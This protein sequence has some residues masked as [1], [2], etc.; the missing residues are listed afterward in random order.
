MPTTTANFAD[1][2]LTPSR[3]LFYALAVGYASALFLLL[4]TVFVHALPPSLLV[5]GVWG[6][7]HEVEQWAW[8]HVRQQGRLVIRCDGQ[9]Q[10]QNTSW[11]LKRLTLRTP[12]LVVFQLRH[13]PSPSYSPLS[14]SCPAKPRTV[15]VA[16]TPDSCTASAY[17]QV[18]LFARYPNGIA[19]YRPGE[20]W[21]R[22]W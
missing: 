14:S 21:R 4:L 7:W 11:T 8:R 10:W 1:I 13:S 3:P 5:L 15:W 18:M 17:H 20:S 22:E 6:L 16:V 2:A 9:I 19:D 12:W